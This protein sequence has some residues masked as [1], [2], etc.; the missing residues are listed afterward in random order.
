MFYTKR[1]EF[2]ILHSQVMQNKSEN[3]SLAEAK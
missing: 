3:Q 1:V 2:E